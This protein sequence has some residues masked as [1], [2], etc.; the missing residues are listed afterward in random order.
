MRFKSAQHSEHA[1]KPHVLPADHRYA[2][3]AVVSGKGV[4]L[5]DYVLAG[6]EPI[7]HLVQC[8]QKCMVFEMM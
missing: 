3:W 8:K 5:R 2:C 1:Q 7:S 6:V 4:K